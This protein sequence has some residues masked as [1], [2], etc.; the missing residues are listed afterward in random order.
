MLFFSKIFAVYNTTFIS[1]RHPLF[2]AVFIL[3]AAPAVTTP[4]A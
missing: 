1:H 3:F 2:F 4:N